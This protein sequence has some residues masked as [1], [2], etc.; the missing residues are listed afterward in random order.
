M[1]EDPG[2][3]AREMV[4][5]VYRADSRRV[6]ATLIRLATNVIMPEPLG[7]MWFTD[8]TTM[9]FGGSAFNFSNFGPSNANVNGS[10]AFVQHPPAVVKST[11]TV[12]PVVLKA[13]TG[14]GA[15]ME[16]VEVTIRVFNNNGEP[17][18]ILGS[19]AR[20]DGSVPTGATGCTVED[21][22]M[23][24]LN[25]SITKP[26]GYI[27]CATGAQQGFVFAEACTGRFHVRQ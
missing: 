19:F 24:T 9:G 22:G 26:G 21:N 20:C 11:T 5:S 13:M 16:M 4:E 25:L 8:R 23:V 6:L 3:P 2:A 27:M 7:A 10:L 12:F 14:G 18:Q 1:S 15:P 17:A